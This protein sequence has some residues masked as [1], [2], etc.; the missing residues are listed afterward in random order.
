MGNGGRSD[1]TRED[2]S[3]RRDIGHKAVERLRGMNGCAAG[4]DVLERGAHG[5]GDDRSGTLHQ[6]EVGRPR[7]WLGEAA[8]A[9]DAL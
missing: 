2:I 9:A 6:G 7:E 5:D 1:D 3:L 4:E 8:Q